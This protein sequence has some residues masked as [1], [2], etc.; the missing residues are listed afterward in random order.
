VESGRILPGVGLLVRRME[1]GERVDIRSTRSSRSGR[2]SRPFF[3]L[4]VALW[5]SRS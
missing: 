4:S 5:R 2:F 3:K 1:V